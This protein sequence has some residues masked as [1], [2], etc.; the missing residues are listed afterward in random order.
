M[1]D[2]AVLKNVVPYVADNYFGVT[3]WCRL[4][5]N[6]DRE[7]A[8]YD[9]EFVGK[10]STG[11]ITWIDNA[12][13]ISASTGTVTWHIMPNL[14]AFGW[15]LPSSSSARSF[16]ASSLLKGLVKSSQG[17]VNFFRMSLDS[18]TMVTVDSRVGF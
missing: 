5:E 18:F 6:G 17:I 1:Y 13:T 10:N 9:L 14:S 4:N 2:G 8:T 7:A 12:A 15:K 11:G 3:G 16:T